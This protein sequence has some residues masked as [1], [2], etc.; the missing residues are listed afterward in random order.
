MRITMLAPLAL[1]AL[2][3]AGSYAAAAES[4]TH[5]AGTMTE[6]TLDHGAKWATDAP[7]RKGMTAI[8]GAVAGALE[9]IHRGGFTT[10]QYDQLADRIEG[11]VHAITR[12]CRLPEQVDAQFHLVLAEMM[13]GVDEMRG[14]A[15]KRSQG[16][17][18]MVQALDAYGRHFD[19][20][21]WKP[22]AH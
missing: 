21:G 4:H 1:A 10:A 12:D 5:N 19:H 18:R 2:L 20:P 3:A 8:R 16:A 14:S 17:V 13:Q 9:P 22:L 6:L 15:P 7:L 11:E